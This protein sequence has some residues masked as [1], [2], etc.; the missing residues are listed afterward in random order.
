M[1]LA[2]KVAIV[3]GASRGIGKA[4]AVG[5]ARE[6]AAVVVAA[7]TETERRRIPG[8]IWETV[9]QIRDNGGRAIGVKVDV[10][11]EGSVDVMVR[12]AVEEF[13][14]VDVL[15]N[16][17]AGAYY[18]PLV[19]TPADRWDLV[20]DVCLRGTYLCSRAVL[21]HMIAQGGGSIV[22]LS[23]LGAE[24]TCPPVTG[25]AYCASK[26]AIERLTTALA[27]EVR[28][29]NVAVNCVKPRSIISTEGMRLQNPDA[30]VS[31][32]DDAEQFMVPAIVFL[33]AQNASGVSGTVLTDEEVCWR[34][35]YLS[36][37]EN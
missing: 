3:T 7:R 11:D 12:K 37:R 29:H 15:V 14:R 32:W 13:G 19:E 30:D 16:N 9:E 5:L 35:D 28:P 10:A 6:G 2:E 33:A 26:A 23:S 8:T 17:A 20:I 4:V 36:R 1:R 25:V 18:R 21:S 22:N 27:D 24:H 34:R 31:I